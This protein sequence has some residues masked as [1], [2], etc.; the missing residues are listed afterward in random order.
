LVNGPVRVLAAG[1]EIKAA[2]A[3]RARCN[4]QVI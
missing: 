3:L 4:D 1:S 2:P